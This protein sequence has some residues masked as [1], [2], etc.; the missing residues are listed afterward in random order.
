MKKLYLIL[1]GLLLPVISWATDAK[2]LPYTSALYQDTEWTVVDNNK[3]GYTWAD[4]EP[5]EAIRSRWSTSQD[6]DD[7]FISPAI[8]F[9]AGRRYLVTVNLMTSSSTYTENCKIML[10]TSADVADL[11]NGTTVYDTGSSGVAS[12]QRWSE[13]KGL[14]T[15]ATEGDYYVGICC[16]SP[17]N[18]AEL[19]LK[20]LSIAEY[21]E[22]PS[23]PTDVKASVGDK[24]VTLSWTLPTTNNA[25]EE[26]SEA[27]T[28]VE[29]YRDDVLAATLDGTATSWTD[30]ES[31]G[32]VLDKSHKYKVY[33]VLAR[34][35][36]V[37]SDEVG[38]YVSS[39]ALSLPWTSDFSSSDAF[40]N[41]WASLRGANSTLAESA[42]DWLWQ[43]KDN[44]VNHIADRVRFVV[45]YSSKADEWLVGPA[46]NFEKAGTY[47]LTVEAANG[48]GGVKNISY[49]LGTGGAISDF[50]QT[51]ADE[52]ALTSLKTAYQYVFNVSTPGIYYLA[53]HCEASTNDTYYIYSMSVEEKVAGTPAQVADLAATVG[54]EQ[55]SL[56]WTYP[57]KDCD[58]A[59]LDVISK[60]E[61]YRDDVLMETLGEVTPGAAATWVDEA[62]N[63]GV[64][65]YW[66]LVYNYSGAAAGDP[67]KVTAKYGNVSTIP[68]TANFFN[69]TKTTSDWE[70][71]TYNTVGDRAY[72]NLQSS[73]TDVDAYFISELLNFEANHVYDFDMLV[74]TNYL[75]SDYEM[76]ITSGTGVSADGQTA[77]Q[78]I[79]V[80]G[81]APYSK[82]KTVNFSL[83]A[84]AD[85]DKK[86][87]DG[88]DGTIPAGVRSVAFHATSTGVANLHN[89]K[90]TENAV[91]T[92]DALASD[93]NYAIANNVLSL[94]R[95][96]SRIVVV[97]LSGKTVAAASNAES[98]DLGGLNDGVYIFNATVGAQRIVGKFVK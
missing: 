27:L 13:Q 48:Y 31:T 16:Y 40:Y 7:W 55:I 51:I 62:P 72:F 64:N 71:K 98:I 70:A 3:D 56:S 77:I 61:I 67:M 94:S 39:G 93:C 2:T 1:L 19:Y 46:L 25:G 66:V 60:V 21:V 29:V 22:V 4:Y 96:A 58:G 24:S 82:A 23:A 17:K 53:A 68:Y 5:K 81:G 45:P 85:G 83:R 78:T 50:T 32:L 79:T 8:H 95:T 88:F 89:F 73:D 87:A 97:D 14:V 28:A 75:G 42:A 76:I 90:I 65:T 47:K 59:D 91:S 49:L 12:G 9:Q 18:H 80:P 54:D 30:D 63:N 41:S 44:I 92:V 38:A 36:S 69:W 74:Y 20:D 52:T 33:A 34:F 43:P 6:A 84:V 26:L 10:A 57:S 86:G 37:A 15:I 11:K 35:K